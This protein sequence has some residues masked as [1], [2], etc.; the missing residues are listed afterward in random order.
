MMTDSILIEIALFLAASVFAAPI[1]RKLGI[2]SVLGHE[3]THGFDDSGRKYD[4]T[5]KR[6]NWWDP[7]TEAIF[8]ERAACL[9]K[10]FDDFSVSG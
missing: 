3:M 9:V 5:G 7:E 8:D 10:Q 6:S 4:A 1:A 2:G